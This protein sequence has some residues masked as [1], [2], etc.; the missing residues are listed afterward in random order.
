MIDIPSTTTDWGVIIFFAWCIW[1]IYAPKFF[2]IETRFE[3]IV[4]GLND[5][6]DA[7]GERIDDLEENH[8][9][10]VAVTEV[11]AIK[12]DEIDGKSVTKIF[13]EE[14]PIDADRIV[15]NGGAEQMADD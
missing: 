13:S 6:I 14:S 1:Q 10:L 15:D 7:V 3:E 5:R 8:E 4:N 11:I 2:N 9:K 12:T